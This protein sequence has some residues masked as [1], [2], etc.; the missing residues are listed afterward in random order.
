MSAITLLQGLAQAL[1]VICFVAVVVTAARHP[2]RAT[3]DAAILFGVIALIVGESQLAAAL[4]L[5]GNTWSSDIASSLLMALPYLL[6][7]LVDDF[8]TVPRLLLRLGTIGLALAVIGLFALPPRAIKLAP[9]ALLYVLYFVGLAGY[10]AVMFIRTARQSSGVTRRRMQAVAVGTLAIGLAILVDG[11]VTVAPARAA[12]WSVLSSLCALA[13]GVGYFVGFAPPPPLR[14]AWQEPEVR[15]FLGRAAR[16]PRLPDTRSIVRELERGAAASIGVPHASILLWDEEAQALCTEVD[17]V[18]FERPIGESIGGRVFVSQRALFWENAVPADPARAE[19]YRAYGANAILGAPITAGEKRLGVLLVYAPR[20]SIFAEDDLVLAQ[21]LADQGA[22]ILE[23]RALIDE[24]ARVRAHA[25][26]TRLKDDFLSAAAHDL[27][28]PLTTL[29]AQAQLMERRAS[30]RP[31]AQAD[32]AGLQRLVGEAQRLKRLVLDL[33]DVSRIEQGQLLGPRE[34]VDLTALAQEVC[35]RHSS[36]HHR[37]AV[38]APQS[39]VGV[40]DRT[41]LTQLLDNLCENAVKYSPEGGTVQVR[42]WQDQDNA[43]LTVADQGIGIPAADLPHLF[44]RFHRG[45]NVDDRRFAGMGLGLYICHSIVTQHGG[46]L[47][48][49]SPGSGQGSTFHVLLPLHEPESAA[50]E[51]APED[52]AVAGTRRTWGGI[53]HDGAPHP[54]RRRRPRHPGH[55]CG[56]SGCGR[57]PCGHGPQ[58]G[59]SAR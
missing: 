38:D 51:T 45:A 21:L 7:R 39:V 18:T 31:D 23:S 40:Y 17:G 5:A 27:K 4:K 11:L 35:A 12:W 3:I 57:L 28:T 36:D 26:A 8:T 29:V 15:A 54:D 32:V 16:L 58:R 14:R 24:A 59:R 44:D 20:P 48:A 1:Y 37:C 49:T 2:R 22:V 19:A 53:A 47:W 6:L 52:M 46:R 9:I 41:R 42:V 50:A 56:V 25:E 55:G 30:R 10:V 33:L 34:E 43:Y 13:S